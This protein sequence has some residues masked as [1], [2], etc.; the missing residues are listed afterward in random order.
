MNA[1]LRADP[2]AIVW[3]TKTLG[4]PDMVA[5]TYQLVL[6]SEAEAVFIISNPNLT[7]KVVYGMQTRGVAAY[8][9]IF[10]S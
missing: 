7:R 4:R 10:D 9:A 6:E 2:D 3:N 8:G 5:L 1:V